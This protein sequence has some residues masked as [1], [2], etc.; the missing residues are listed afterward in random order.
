[1]Y[2]Q[3]QP[4]YGQQQPGFGMQPGYGQPPQQMYQPGFNQ[5]PPPPI[6]QQGF[7]PQQGPTIIHIN[8]DDDDGTPC[9][10]CRSKTSH[11]TRRKVGC[12]AIAWCFCLLLTVG[13]CWLPCCMDGCKDI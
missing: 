11:I 12:V 5:P 2:G 9:Q 13:L 8:N 6:Y 4:M 10:F 1:M 3:P 7:Q